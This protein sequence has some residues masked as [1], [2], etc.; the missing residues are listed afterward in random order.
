MR[1]EGT[2]R[3]NKTN[4]QGMEFLVEMV[5]IPLLTKIFIPGARDFR[6]EGTITISIPMIGEKVKAEAPKLAEV[7]VTGKIQGIINKVRG[8]RF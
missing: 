4:P 7:A 1:Y 5:E 6:P 2:L 3:L 8:K